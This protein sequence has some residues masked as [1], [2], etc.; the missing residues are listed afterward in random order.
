MISDWAQFALA[1]ALVVVTTRQGEGGEE[2]TGRGQPGYPD[3]ALDV[4]RHEEE[5]RQKPDPVADRTIH[6]S[7]WLERSSRALRLIASRQRIAGTSML[8]RMSNSSP[9]ELWPIT[10]EIDQK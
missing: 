2:S 6:L 7:P 1:S 10:F 5:Q 3:D 4:V 8:P 9:R